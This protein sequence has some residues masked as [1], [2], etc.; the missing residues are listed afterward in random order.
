A[1]SKQAPTSVVLRSEIDEGRIL[2]RDADVIDLRNADAGRDI[3]DIGPRLPAIGCAKDAAV[4]AH[5]ERVAAELQ[6]MNIGVYIIA[7]IVVVPLRGSLP[8][9]AAVI[10]P[11][12]VDAAYVHMIDI[13]G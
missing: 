1:V 8:G 3:G 11:P 5:I 10:G 7:L 6:R 2:G 9:A 13:A 12:C 4:A